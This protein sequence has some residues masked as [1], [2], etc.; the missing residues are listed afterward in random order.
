MARLLTSPP[1]PILSWKA[2]FTTISSPFV[3]TGDPDG[4]R[5][6]AGLAGFTADE[7]ADF[8]KMSTTYLN[9]CS[10]TLYY[11]EQ[12]VRGV[13]ELTELRA[14]GA[15][16]VAGT[17][18]RI[19]ILKL[20]IGEARDKRR[21]LLAERDTVANAGLRAFIT[22]L[23]LAKLQDIT[24]TSESAVDGGDRTAWHIS[25][26]VEPAAGSFAL[27]RR[28]VVPAHLSDAEIERVLRG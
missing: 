15:E 16:A 10:K 11:D 21:R 3:F 17:S 25:G 27:R 13:K 2:C 9:A 23:E 5:S 28:R 26:P 18:A 20:D 4:W 19:A 14:P 8:E 22:R 6:V 1:P 7:F 24:G 12:L